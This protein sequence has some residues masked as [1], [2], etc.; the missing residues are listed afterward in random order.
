[1]AHNGWIGVDLDGTL[2]HYDTWRGAS[3][4]GAPIEPMRQRVLK[5]LAAGT[6]V[7]IFTARV[8]PVAV[9]LNGNT[10]EETVKPIQDWCKE[11]LGV[12]LPVTHEKD[13]GM[14]L[15]YDDRCK[16]VIPNTGR[17]VD[18]SE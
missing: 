4:I 9:A 14:F 5:F 8:S 6:E 11:H 13:M 18:G 2:A 16:Q 7:R 15:L 10:L 3:H 1:M 12:V 17:C